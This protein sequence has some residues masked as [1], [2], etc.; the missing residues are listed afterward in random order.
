MKRYINTSTGPIQ[1]AEISVTA[2]SLQACVS[3][4]NSA[5]VD[6]VEAYLKQMGYRV[7][8]HTN[9]AE[10]PML[11]VTGPRDEAQFI[12]QLSALGGALAPEQVKKPLD[13]WITRSILGF[14][15]Q[16]LQLTSSLMKH[17]VD[18]PLL[19]F[20][21]TNLTANGINFAY[22][23][24]KRDDPHQLKFL[25][26]QIND[27]LAP[28]LTEDKKP[29]DINDTRALL[30]E[31]NR[32]K[33]TD[34]VNEFMRQHS[35]SVGELG[36][37]YVGAFGM[38]FPAKGWGPA[39]S[40]GRM[41][42]TD[43]NAPLRSV[44]GIGSIIGKTIAAGSLVPDPYNPEQG[45]HWLQ[46][47]RE[48]Y[49]F[50]VGGLV[51]AA[52]FS[53]L[54]YDAL[55]NS[56]PNI[57]NGVNTNSRSLKIGNSYH[58]DWL[59]AIGSAMFVTGYIVRS[60]AKFGERE[61]NMPELYAHVSDTLALLPREKIPQALADTAAYLT[62]HFKGKRDLTFGHIYNQIN[63][64]LCR[65]H[66]ISVAMPAVG[67]A[68]EHTHQPTVASPDKTPPATQIHAGDVVME[69]TLEQDRALQRA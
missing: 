54:T 33:P 19:L 41:P 58:R 45:H 37:R 49:S 36:L 18:G 39:L 3:L 68:L 38:A 50:L 67:I 11:V 13:P 57:V 5:E 2:E 69:R 25:K 8:S 64:D 52:S 28:Q 10:K 22:K 30:R 16:L 66:H 23:A 29:L 1:S 61:V 6:R 15:G 4:T 31:R 59:S 42:P 51:E 20:A 12:G 21:T 44:A 48:K 53:T 56:K 14:G 7:Q 24:Q 26:Q 60:W 63:D 34:P 62:D 55:V 17:K 27:Q 43:K 40:Q 65:E 9:V 35:V 32:P 47:F 46:D